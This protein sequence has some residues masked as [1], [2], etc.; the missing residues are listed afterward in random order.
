MVSTNSCPAIAASRQM[1][2]CKATNLAPSRTGQGILPSNQHGSR[3][4]SH[5][6]SRGPPPGAGRLLHPLRRP[7][8]SNE[9]AHDT[10]LPESVS[11]RPASRRPRRRTPRP[12]QGLLLPRGCPPSRRSRSHR[13]RPGRRYPGGAMTPRRG[14]TDPPLPARWR[15]AISLAPGTWCLTASSGSLRSSP[16]LRPARTSCRPL[17]QGPGRNS[18]SAPSPSPP[19]LT[20]T[21]LSRRPPRSRSTK[22]GFAPPST[23][24]CD[25]P[26]DLVRAEFHD[27]DALR[28]VTHPPMLVAVRMPG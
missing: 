25:R 8:A 10:V 2:M 14:D 7:A 11:P 17:P 5:P 28:S 27:S 13:S 1:D 24:S 22:F 19:M 26:A 23:G 18:G 3:T 21:L 16:C 9:K 6:P 15:V 12:R 20:P 4:G